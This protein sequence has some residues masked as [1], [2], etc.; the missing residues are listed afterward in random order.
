MADLLLELLVTL[1]DTELWHVDP[2]EEF[3]GP[4]ARLLANAAVVGLDDAVE[5]V[6]DA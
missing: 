1:E 2:L 5:K 6:L 3:G 4:F